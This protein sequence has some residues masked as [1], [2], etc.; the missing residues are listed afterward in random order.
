MEGSEKEN[1]CPPPVHSVSLGVKLTQL[2][3]M[4]ALKATDERST[5]KS[6]YSH[7]YLNKIITCTYNAI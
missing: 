2:I 4:N 7:F 3:Y 1:I 5:K 6:L